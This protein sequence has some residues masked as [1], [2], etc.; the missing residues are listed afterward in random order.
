MVDVSSDDCV[1]NG[2][3]VTRAH[4]IARRTPY[5]YTRGDYIW[6]V[7]QIINYQ[8]QSDVSQTAIICLRLIKNL[9]DNYHISISVVDDNINEDASSS[10]STCSLPYIFISQYIGFSSQAYM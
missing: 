3:I 8:M 2:S 9:C 6:P 1:D 5:G 7:K 4:G 10:Q